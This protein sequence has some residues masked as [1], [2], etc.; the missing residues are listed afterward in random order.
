MRRYSGHWL[1]THPSGRQEAIPLR[2]SELRIGSAADNDIVLLGRGIAP[3]HATVRCS[4]LGDLLIASAGLE[5]ELPRSGADAAVLR[6][7][8]YVLNYV[9]EAVADQSNGYVMRQAIQQTQHARVDETEF[10]SA[11]LARDEWSS[12]EPQPLGAH[13]AIT[14]EM[15]ALNLDR[16]D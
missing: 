13:E 1:V 10:L 8:G 4:E 16:A 7:G 9:A 11:L 6:I 3:R 14:L 12:G 5:I 15:P 2:A